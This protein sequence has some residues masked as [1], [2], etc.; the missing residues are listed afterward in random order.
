MVRKDLDFQR[1][2]EICTYYKIVKIRV[3]SVESKAKL[4]KERSRKRYRKGKG[5]IGGAEYVYVTGYGISNPVR[6]DSSHVRVF[7]HNIIES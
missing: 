2:K 6:S 3:L 5:R 7:N 4:P 1:E